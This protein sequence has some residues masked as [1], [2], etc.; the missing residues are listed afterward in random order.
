MNFKSWLMSYVCTECFYISF[1]F[2]WSSTYTAF[3]MT[4]ESWGHT[5]VSYA[6]LTSSLFTGRIIGK[7]IYK[8]RHSFHIGVTKTNLNTAFL[9]LAVL[10]LLIAVITRYSVLVIL[11]FLVGFTAARVGAS[12]DD[13]QDKESESSSS[14]RNIST[15]SS[16]LETEH[17]AK[18][19]IAIF[20][21]STLVSSLLY[22]KTSDAS[23]SFPAYYACSFFSV[24]LIGIFL[25]NVLSDRSMLQRL[26]R[27][28]PCRRGVIPKS[29]RVGECVH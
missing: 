14:T 5:V 20:M 10:F 11:Y 28:L 22:N 18:R 12:Q 13:D 26:C 16:E 19:K 8:T 23:V 27:Y 4:G 29:R 7:V 24:V 17:L 9:I 25:L 21:F 1:L 6:F 2:T 3:C 15:Y